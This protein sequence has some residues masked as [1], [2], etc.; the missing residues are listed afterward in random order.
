MRIGYPCINRTVGCRN[1]RTFR[2]KSYSEQRLV[3]TVA[4]NLACLR[5]ILE[6]NVSHGILFFRITSDLVPFASHPICQ[7]DWRGHFAEVLEG[8]GS[9]IKE[10]AIRISMHPDQFIVVNSVNED[11]FRRSVRELLYHA[12]LL[13]AMGL[14]ASAKVQI[15]IGG[16]YG[17]KQRSMDRFVERFGLLDGAITRRLVIENDDR[18]YTLADCMQVH[19]CTGVPVLL[20]LFHHEVNPSGGSLRVALQEIS[21]TWQQR[22]GIPMLD[23]STQQPDTRPGK[24]AESINLVHFEQFLQQS[25]PFDMDV[26]LEIKDKEASAK[27]AIEV[28]ALDARFVGGGPRG[29]AHGR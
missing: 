4:S 20:D 28:A 1:N 10:H 14:D 27:R 3:E 7:F 18:S 16:V 21:G 25:H 8:I 26:M 6:F 12:M 19:A 11:V 9:F 2:L 13:D 5:R 22:D 23:Y 29:E 15:H 17:D 24:H